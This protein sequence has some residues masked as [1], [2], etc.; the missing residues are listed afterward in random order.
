M[1]IVMVAA[2]TLTA[3]SGRDT[4][5]T[6]LCWCQ[7]LEEMAAELA[8]NEL[9]VNAIGWEEAKRLRS[10]EMLAAVFGLKAD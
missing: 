6:H 4:L 2:A 1:L 7:Q 10:Y 8:I 9:I 3:V 5:P